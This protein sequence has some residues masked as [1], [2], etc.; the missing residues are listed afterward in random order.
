MILRYVV[1][2]ILADLRLNSLS[3]RGRESE[4]PSYCSRLQ[5]WLSLRRTSKSIDRVLSQLI[6][7]DQP[8][9]ILLRQKQLE[10]L[11]FIIEAL[12]LTADMRH[13]NTRLNVPK[14]KFLCGKFWHNPDLSAS[15]VRNIMATLQAH[16]HLTLQ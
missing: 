15:T 4:V 14:L 1:Q 10:K 2:N 12:I 9:N 6:V 7:E 8:L 16:I 11:N 5:Q 3:V 13:V